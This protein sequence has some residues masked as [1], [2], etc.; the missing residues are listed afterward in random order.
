[1][2]E[3]T[4]EHQ[5]VVDRY[6]PPEETVSLRGRHQ[7][8]VTLLSGAVEINSD[9]RVES[10][11]QIILEKDKKIAILSRK[12]IELV[13]TADTRRESGVL[14]DELVKFLAEMVTAFVDHT[15]AGVMSGPGTT[16]PPMIN[17]TS[18]LRS[19]GTEETLKTLILSKLIKLN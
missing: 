7:N 2:A 8:D 10:A 9:R 11:E 6:I 3:L 14:G 4:K 13:N 19:K 18:Q 1:M 17:Y 5:K 16:P 15:H 12:L